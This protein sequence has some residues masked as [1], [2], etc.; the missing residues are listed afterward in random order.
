MRDWKSRL[1]AIVSCGSA[2]LAALVQRFRHFSARRSARAG[3]A[4]AALERRGAASW[5]AVALGRVEPRSREIK[6]TRAGAGPHRRRAGQ[7]Q[8]QGVCRRTAGSPR[9]RGGVGARRR[10]RGPG[11][12]RKRARN[13]QS[14]PAGAADRRKAEDAVADAERAIV[15]ARSAL[16]RVAVEWRAGGAHRRP[17]SRRRAP[18]VA[19]AGSSARAARCAREAQGGARRRLPTPIG[20]RAQRG[21]R[22]MD[23]GAGG[24]GEDRIRAPIDGTVL[25]VDA[26][27]GELAVP[28]LEPALLVLGDVSAL[29]VRAEV[30]EQYLGRMRVGQRVVVRAAAFAAATSTARS[31]RSP[32]SSVR[33]ASIRAARASSTTSTCWRSPSICRIPARWWSASRSTSTSRRRAARRGRSNPHCHCEPPGLPSASPRVNSAKQSPFARACVRGGDCFV[34]LRPPRNDGL[35]GQNSGATSPTRS[36]PRNTTPSA[37][38]S[39]SVTALR[40]S[41]SAGWPSMAA[42]AAASAA[43]PRGPSRRSRLRPGA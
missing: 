29:R 33:A 14:T 6:I 20:G 3:A 26:R 36:G 1:M 11:R 4:A 32:A 41:S 10:G 39:G 7:G 8:R 23:A 42:P 24:A 13:D 12:S 43:P 27:K 34:G 21:A 19:R 9:R 35:R 40:P 18:L 15:D 2:S 37:K 22:R 25:Q 28:S 16:D 38:R 17:I 31:R 30:D 5:D